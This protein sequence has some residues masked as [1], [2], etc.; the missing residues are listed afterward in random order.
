MNSRSFYL[1]RRNPRGP[2]YVKF[3]NPLTGEIGSYKSTGESDRDRASYIAQKWLYEG[4]PEGRT[5]KPKN[6]GEYFTKESVFEKLRKLDLTPEDAQRILQLLKKKELITNTKLGTVNTNSPLF[7]SWLLDMWN[8]ETSPYIKEKLAHG[9]S[10]GKRRSYDAIR[11]I[12]KH[13]AP[14]F[15]GVN[16]DELTR[17]NLKDF[18]LHLSEKGL[19]AK[20]INNILSPGTVILKWAAQNDIIKTDPSIG[21]R[22]FSGTAQKRGILTDKEV[23]TLFTDG[24]WKDPKVRLA[25]I[26]ASVSGLRNGEIL[27]LQVQDI[28]EDRIYVR[29]NWSIKD[30]L[31]SPKNGLSREV[32]IF[33][34]LRKELLRWARRHP[35]GMSPEHFLFYSEITPS[36]PLNG[37][38]LSRHLVSALESIGI[39]DKDRKERKIDFHSWRH[40]FAT[41]LTHKV[42]QNTA[43]VTGHLDQKM[44]EHYSNHSSEKDFQEIYDASAQIFSNTFNIVEENAV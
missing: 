17:H 41:L 39:S 8:H 13:W 6:P 38:T 2:Y 4:M 27:A 37:G 30:G 5:Q 28:G 14:F 1:Y 29:H 12:E 25:N 11:S 23:N 26:L 10:L 33:P 18:S 9:H 44:L 20:S 32:P 7:I 21:L 34:T 42:G 16:R 19:A 40:R 15:E 24:I 22:K 43:R 3:R 31:K 36:I 35:E